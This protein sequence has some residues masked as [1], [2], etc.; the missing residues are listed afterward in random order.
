[1]IHFILNPNA[2]T[3]SSQKRARI[4]AILSAIPETKIWI[5]ERSN[6]ASELTKLALVDGASKII[7][8][9]GD[10]TINE[11][12]SSLI[13]SQVPLG[14]IPMGSGNGLARH[15]GLPFS[16]KEALNKAIKGDKITIDTGLWNEQPFFCTAGIG[17]D[18][19]VASHFAR[20]GKRG[21]LNY[22][23]S[24]LISLTS[25]K[26]IEIEN[27]GKVFSFTVANANQFGNNAFISPESDLQDGN[28][29]CV[30]IKNASLF[31]LTILGISLF[32]K[33]LHK[34][35]LA[36]ISCIKS[37]TIHTKSGI[38]FHLDGESFIL[39]TD[40]IKI[41]ILPASLQVIK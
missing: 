30:K 34:S 23:Y 25:Y 36:E 20:S 26:P 10:G 13:H 8:I 38:P 37:L 4:M 11:V 27:I 2:G 21:F 18:A 39:E 40:T 5:T 16:F 35:S 33:N 29:E 17:F 1:M 15:L 41:N 22:I 12:A 24:T 6:H 32:R 14:I 31:S 28:L 19:F 7:A 3:N 9:G